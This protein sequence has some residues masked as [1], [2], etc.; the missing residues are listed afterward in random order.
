MLLAVLSAMPMSRTLPCFQ[1]PATSSARVVAVMMWVRMPKC[2]QEIGILSGGIA[3]FAPARVRVG[4][5]DRP[6]RAGVARAETS[7]P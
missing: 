2:A 5:E 1:Y 3:A 7:M 6:G 4:G